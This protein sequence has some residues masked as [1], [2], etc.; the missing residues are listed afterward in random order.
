M[1]CNVISISRALAAGGEEIGRDVAARLGFR[2]VDDEI[3]SRAAHLAGV[4]PE[5]IE[6]VERTPS[7]ID[8]ILNHLG[9]IPAEGAGYLPAPTHLRVNGYAGRARCIWR[10]RD[11]VSI[12]VDG[13]R[14][15]QREHAGNS[16]R[17]ALDSQSL[18]HAGPTFRGR[19]QV[20]GAAEPTTV[21]VWYGLVIAHDVTALS[22]REQVA[23]VGGLH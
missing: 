19:A 5:T 2:F 9:S 1:D 6:K 22:T 18:Q 21:A 14:Q 16:G 11:V 20:K 7:L 8:R 10:E 13:T 4:S 23:R 17:R 15:R 12:Q 3:V